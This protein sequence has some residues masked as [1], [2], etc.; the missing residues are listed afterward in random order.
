MII[1]T[2]F[3]NFYMKINLIINNLLLNMEKLIVEQEFLEN[4]EDENYRK[5]FIDQIKVEVDTDLLERRSINI[6]SDIDN[7]LETNGLYG[8]ICENLSIE[9]IIDYIINYT[10]S[11]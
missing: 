11:F 9:K 7:Y 2:I 8:K 3:V 5:D 10:K 4:E 6:Y 1:S